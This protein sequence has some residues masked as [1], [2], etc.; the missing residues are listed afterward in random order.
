LR[1]YDRLRETAVL[2]ERYRVAGLSVGL[3]PTMGALHA[4]HLALIEEARQECERVVV[5]AFVNPTQFGQGED[6]AAYPRSREA[7]SEACR[8]AGVDLV[9]FAADDEI[10]PRGF[11]TWVIVESLTRP[12]CGSSRPTHF[13][14]VATVVTQLL[15]IVRPHRAYFGQKDY[16]Q[17]RVIERLV[18]DLHLGVDIRVVETVRESDGLAMSSR[19]AYLTRVEREAVPRIRRALLAAQERVVAGERSVDQILEIINDTL[20]P[21]TELKID[22]AEVRNAV[23]L[24]EFPDAKVVRDPGV[25]IAVAVNVGTAR[26]IDNVVIG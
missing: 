13:R 23:T 7:D 22:Y 12:L 8:R 3:V 18:T 16:Q 10:Y 1:I 21:G 24:Q 25:L 6:L 9:Y 11:Q 20:E 2:C 5:S 15:H 4:G 19:N 14:G 17:F 26:L